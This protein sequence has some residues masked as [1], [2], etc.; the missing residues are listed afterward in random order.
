MR[1]KIISA[2]ILLMVLLLILANLPSFS[3]HV[4]GS[5][6]AD[7][8]LDPTEVFVA[9][10]GAT[11]FYGHSINYG[12]Y[13]RDLIWPGP[14]GHD[15]YIGMLNV[16]YVKITNDPITRFAWNQ[17]VKGFAWVPAGGGPRAMITFTYPAFVDSGGDTHNVVVSF[18]VWDRPNIPPMPNTD[19]RIRVNAVD[20]IN[21]V[22]PGPAFWDFQIPIRAD[23]DIFDIMSPGLDEVFICSPTGLP[24]PNHWFWN[25]PQPIET[26]YGPPGGRVV[27]PIYGCEVYQHDITTAGGWPGGEPWAG[28]VPFSTT[29]AQADVFTL[30]AYNPPPVNEYIGPPAPYV[31]GQLIA[32]T[33]IVIWDETTLRMIPP[34][35]PPAT[36]TITVDVWLS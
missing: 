4:P 15:R 3:A 32:G 17:V 27:D 18:D 25:G 30:L 9:V 24:P 12:S 22:L 1:K 36:G 13:I 19:V 7:P 31:N 29:G 34:A 20:V 6:P 10:G 16:P 33:D 26:I 35:T 11:F 21:F 14:H 5:N 2:I 28:I 23:F 8:A